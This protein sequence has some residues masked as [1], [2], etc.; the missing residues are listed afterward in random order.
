[1]NSVIGDNASRARDLVLVALV[2]VL[3]AQFE[4]AAM[5]KLPVIAMGLV[6]M[7]VVLATFSHMRPTTVLWLTG[8][9]AATG[10][11][12][13]FVALFAHGGMPLVL[14]S[15]PGLSGQH[16]AVVW[17][18]APAF[19]SAVLGLWARDGGRHWMPAVALCGAAAA[20]MFG[21]CHLLPVL[22]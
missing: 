20:A 22:G 12:G 15:G 5:A 6:A 4:F 2:F 16:A 17:F 3:A 10:F 7:I 1:M 8:G 14:S 11:S 13:L 19:A 21:T 9:A 18:M